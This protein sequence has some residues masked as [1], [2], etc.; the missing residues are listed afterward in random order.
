MFVHL[1]LVCALSA[2]NHAQDVSDPQAISL[3][4]LAHQLSNHE[5][6]ARD[7]T[8]EASVD[9]YAAANERQAS[10]VQLGLDPYEI[11]TTPSGEIFVRVLN[12]DRFANPH[13]G[14]QFC[15]VGTWHGST[16][17]C[18]A[19]TGTGLGGFPSGD[20]H[21]RSAWHSLGVSLLDV[22]IEAGDPVPILIFFATE[23]SP[24]PESGRMD[25]AIRVYSRNALRRFGVI[26]KVGQIVPV[27]EFLGEPVKLAPSDE[28][29]TQGKC[30]GKL[31]LEWPEGVYDG[32][33]TV[34]QTRT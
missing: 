17:E 3:A 2:S 13:F 21:W 30:N 26:H 25:S 28:I 8:C 24:K 6:L 9:S 22:P 7:E 31:A 5:V 34:M 1:A 20:V 12:S 23:R 19:L 15:I 33:V 14:T 10:Y 4:C 27:S 18:T 29:P 16:T 32:V 11:G